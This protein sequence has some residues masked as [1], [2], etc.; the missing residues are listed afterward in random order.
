M[1]PNDVMRKWTDQRDKCG[2]AEGKPWSVPGVKLDNGKHGY[3]S[4]VIQFEVVRLDIETTK[5]FKSEFDANA[6]QLEESEETRRLKRK[7]SSCHANKDEHDA[8]QHIF[9]DSPT[10]REIVWRREQHFQL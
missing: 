6:T 10:K 8:R 3:D 1:L 4:V 7:I 5:K 9:S 2:K